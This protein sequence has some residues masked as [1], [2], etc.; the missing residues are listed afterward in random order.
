MRLPYIVGRLS[1]MFEQIDLKT[2]DKSM[3]SLLGDQWMLITAGTE[4][5]CNTM[6]ASWGGVGVL[7]GEPMATIFVRPQRYTKEF[8]DQQEY[9]SLCF[10]PE[11]FRKDLVFCGKE[12][13]REKDKIKDCGFT[14]AYDKAP[15]MEQA[16]LVLLCRKRYRQSMDG[17]AIAT[18]VKERWYPQ[19]DYH[20]I[21]FGE[22]VEALKKV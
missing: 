21:Y 12:S 7:W 15:Y 10:F 18:E 19:E 11:S 3:V 22:I 17:N 6:T 4:H 2:Y 9:F 13:G 1:I 8:I 14:M 16:D 20:D 5:S